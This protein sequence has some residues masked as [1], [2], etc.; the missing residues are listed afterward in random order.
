MQGQAERQVQAE[1]ILDAMQKAAQT[2]GT[3][4]RI[5]IVMDGGCL[6]PCGG[7]HEKKSLHVYPD[8]RIVYHPSPYGHHAV[9]IPV[10]KPYEVDREFALSQIAEWVEARRWRHSVW[11]SYWEDRGVD[12]G[13]WRE[14]TLEELEAL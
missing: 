6:K 1:R 4:V 5:T 11:W 13:E 10:P 2:L 8:G 14:V 12:D 7:V 3:P 9:R